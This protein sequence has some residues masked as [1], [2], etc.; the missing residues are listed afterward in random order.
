MFIKHSLTII[1][2]CIYIC[3]VKS[4]DSNNKECMNEDDSEYAI[5][6]DAGSTGSRSFI[7]Q[8]CQD[9][10][11][12]RI[13]KSTKGKKLIPGLSSFADNPIDSVEYMLPAFI[14]AIDIIPKDKHLTTKVFIKGTAGMR[15]LSDNEQERIWKELASGLTNHKDIPFFIKYENLGTIDGDF[16]AYYAVLSSNYIAGSINGNLLR[17][18][19]TNMIGALDMGGSSTQ[20]IFHIETKNNAPVQINDFWLHSWLNYGVEKIREKVI[21]LLIVGYNDRLDEEFKIDVDA[22][23][24]V[25]EYL[26][27]IIFIDNPCLFIGHELESEKGVTFIGTGDAIECTKLIKKVIWSNEDE[28]NCH[29]NVGKPCPINGIISPYISG[30]FYGMSVYFFALDCIKD[31]GPTPLAS[32]PN[33]SLN[34]IST[35]VYDFCSLDWYA[36]ESN[37]LSGK[38]KFTQDSQLPHRC[39]EALYMIVLLENGFGFD[40]EARDITLALEVH[41][42][43]VEWTLGYALAEIQ[44]I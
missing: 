15:L 3:Y 11:N 4:N 36:V 1:I 35:S 23:G 20:L 32:W 43:E 7:F 37:M 18:Q 17:I 34:E 28:A 40:R 38:H 16:E 44:K 10:H 33:P 6:I 21:A 30:K 24:D 31:L 8:F 39:L 22:N 12:E 13:V 29:D 9:E 19:D 5:V 41:G 42:H 25:G 14:K 26:D 27:E 2:F